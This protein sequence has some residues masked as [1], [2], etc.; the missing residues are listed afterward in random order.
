MKYYVTYFY[1]KGV[2]MGFGSFFATVYKPIKTQ[3][4][5]C[6]IRAYIEEEYNIEKAVILDYK[7]LEVNE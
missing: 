6:R 1:I 2:E 3:E 5:I 4:D 7:L